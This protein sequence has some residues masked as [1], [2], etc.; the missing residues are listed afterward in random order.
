MLVPR[1]K[2]RIWQLQTPQVNHNVP[3][4]R[5]RFNI[6]STHKIRR[7][8]HALR[9]HIILNG[10]RSLTRWRL[11]GNKESRELEIQ[12]LNTV[13]R[14]VN[15]YNLL[16]CRLLRVPRQCDTE[17]NI[18]SVTWFTKGE[19]PRPSNNNAFWVDVTSNVFMLI[20]CV[21]SHYMFSLYFHCFLDST[22][23]AAH[24]WHIDGD[25]GVLPGVASIYA[26]RSITEHSREKTWVLCLNRERHTHHPPLTLTWTLHQLATVSL[27]VLR[28]AQ[29]HPYKFLL[30]P[31]YREL[32]LKRCPHIIAYLS[33]VCSNNSGDSHLMFWDSHP[34]YS[35][36]VS[37]P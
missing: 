22:C 8:T 31:M 4:L 2:G 35:Q 12:P 28:P 16:S 10:R 37:S 21:T 3:A 5:Y 20:V 34:R 17:R 33:Y 30:V 14:V 13:D 24:A 29:F 7:G 26:A 18:Q 36:W 6:C 9:W 11:E 25:S 23:Q 15:F 19:H 1:P 32:K 27:Q